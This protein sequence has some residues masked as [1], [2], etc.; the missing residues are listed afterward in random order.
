MSID[1]PEVKE[2]E[3]AGWPGWTKVQIGSSRRYIS[4]GGTE[5]SASR[6]LHLSQLYKGQKYIPESAI[7]EDLEKRPKSTG[8]FGSAAGNQNRKPKSEIKIEAETP[9]AMEYA[10]L[11]EPEPRAKSHTGSR[12]H[13]RPSQIAL[14]IGF[15]KLSLLITAV[16]IARLVNDDRAALSEEEATA[17]G[18][19]LGN[20]LVDSDWNEK[21]GWLVAE[22]GDW[23]MVGYV[24]FKWVFRMSEVLRDKADER[25]R[26]TQGRNPGNVPQGTESGAGGTGGGTPNGQYQFVPNSTTS[27][28]GVTK[29]ARTG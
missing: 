7:A 11:V 5:I 27:P 3:V 8:F 19:A 10:D 20:L 15:K 22:T 12:K 21:Y 9:K 24:C 16:V 23:Q 1:T 29:F 28:I 18:I 25:K 6:F 17:L 2:K 26:H 4:P 13:P 14:A